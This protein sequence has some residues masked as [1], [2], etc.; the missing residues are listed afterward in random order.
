MA[1]RLALMADLETPVPGI[2]AVATPGH[3]PGHISFVIS[4][5]TAR[6][7]ILGD[8]IHCPVEIGQSELDFVFDVDPKL[9]RETKARIE[10]ELA[11]PDTVTVGAHF[12]NL[13][14]GRVLPGSAPLSIDFSV[15][16]VLS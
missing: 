6:A 14:F 2:T 9:N 3:T 8:M 11:R 5:G 4:S 15:S 12:P 7:V 16:K 1:K 10:R 13:V